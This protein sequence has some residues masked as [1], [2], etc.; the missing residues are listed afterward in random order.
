LLSG[1]FFLFSIIKANPQY[2][3]TSFY[4]VAHQDDWQYFMGINAAH[5]LKNPGTKVV[6]LFITAGDACKGTNACSS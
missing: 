2:N 5:D 1:I 3:S 4:I 6:F